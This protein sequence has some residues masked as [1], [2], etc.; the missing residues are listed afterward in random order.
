MRPSG[1]T[2]LSIDEAYTGRKA[3]ASSSACA[4]FSINIIHFF[5]ANGVVSHYFAC[6]LLKA[7]FT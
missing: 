3:D 4:L 6:W 2:R 1:S 5:A 7:L